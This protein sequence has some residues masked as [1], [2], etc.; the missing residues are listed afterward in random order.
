MIN[1][2]K[3]CSAQYG[4]GLRLFRE[5]NHDDNEKPSIVCCILFML[6]LFF[7]IDLNN[8]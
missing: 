6:V 5:K 7:T 1:Y 3:S 8:L 2:F 4:K